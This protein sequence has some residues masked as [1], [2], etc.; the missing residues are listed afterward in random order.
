ME[1]LEIQYIS[2]SSIIAFVRLFFIQLWSFW[3]AFLKKKNLFYRVIRNSNW[4]FC[5]LCPFSSIIS[6]KFHISVLIEML[7][8]FADFVYPIFRNHVSILILSKDIFTAWNLIDNA[9]FI[10]HWNLYR[11]FRCFLRLQLYLHNVNIFF[12]H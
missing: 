9:K 3:T 5:I 2:C 1:N 12:L 7:I 4:M 11:T 6:Q 10:V 8:I